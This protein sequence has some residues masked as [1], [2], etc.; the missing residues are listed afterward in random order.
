MVSA[1][2]LAFYVL[3]TLKYKSYIENVYKKKKYKEKVK[4]IEKFI[5]ITKK[6]LM[7]K[8][9][10]KISLI[11]SETEKH[12]DSTVKEKMKVAE[13]QLEARTNESE[14]IKKGGTEYRTFI[15]GMRSATPKTDEELQTDIE[16][17]RETIEK[18]EF[19]EDVLKFIE[20]RKKDIGTGIFYEKMSRR[21][22]EI[23]NKHKLNEYR[24]IPFQ[25]LKFHAFE[26]I[27]N[28]KNDDFL[29]ILNLMKET[30]LLYDIVELNPNFYII[31]FEEEDYK[32]TNPEKVVLTF[33]YDEKELNIRKLLELT[34]W[35]YT[36]ADKIL[37]NMQEKEI[38]SILDEKIIIQG[39]GYLDERIQWNSRIEE[40]IKKEKLK[41]K[42]KLEKKLALKARIRER[43]KE[44]ERQKTE[45][46]KE[47]LSRKKESESKEKDEIQIQEG[48]P[49]KVSFESKPTVK[50]L[51]PTKKTTK[52]TLEDLNDLDL[53]HIELEEPKLKELIPPKVLSFH[54]NFSML[55][56][57]FA[58]Y[59]KIKQYIEEEV[60]N[61]PDDL[62][63]D[64]LKQLREL[65]FI[66]SSTKI[67]KYRYYL[68]KEMKLNQNERKFISFIVNKPPM[69]KEELMKGLKWGEGRTLTTM[70]KLQDKGI[71][72]IKSNKVI[73]PG[74]IQIE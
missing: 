1:I 24:I 7:N 22:K 26:E 29:P 31:I 19:L 48:E 57:G 14:I 36:Y 23:I 71:L 37:S 46:A 55:N 25:R 58:Q 59:E 32:F 41:E 35:D 61:V 64:I 4:Q 39:Y 30:N 66:F 69:E 60:E 40:H 47:T 20:S 6:D 8:K 3:L 12:I 50:S 18:L 43:V 13:A 73:I 62:L 5:P 49:A 9:L 16:N 52:L 72:R 38:L 21:F 44:V 70:K 56:G 51:P 17:L 15:A 10:E 42:E 74:I 2:F 11:I 54:E 68:F 27:K 53:D 65:K 34:E 63:K 33:A 28:I 45:Q 67:R